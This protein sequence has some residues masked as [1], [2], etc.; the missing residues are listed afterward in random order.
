MCAETTTANFGWTKPDPGASANTWG[1]TLNATTDKVD[2]VAWAAQQAS[3]PVGTVIMYAGGAA[4]KNWMICNGSSLDTT[5]YATL[6]AVIGFAFGG[7]GSSFSL[8]NLLQKFPM[9]AGPNPLGQYGGNFSVTLGYGNMPAH[10]HNV[11]VSNPAHYHPIPAWT[12][13][14]SAYQDVH[15]HAAY[16]DAHIHSVA[17][18]THSHNITTGGHSHNLTAYNHSHGNQLLRF[19]GSGGQFGITGGGPNV[20]M[21]NTDG[22]GNFGGNTDAPGS[23]GGYTDAQ[24]ANIGLADNRQP[25][26]YTD[27]RQPAVHMSTDVANIPYADW[28][29]TSITASVDVQGSTA[30]FTVVP[31]FQAINFIIRYI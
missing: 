7:S 8:P 13:T 12:H 16:Q 11:Y 26:V 30:P 3:V 23:L 17:N 29:T 10:A 20:N 31:P 5:N 4:P 19:V 25:G 28:T 1:A 2:A 9:G 6:F 18:G 15:V 14:H 24:Y 22:S 27:N 21:G